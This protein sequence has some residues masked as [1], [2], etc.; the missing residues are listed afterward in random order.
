[1]N[2]VFSKSEEWQMRF[3]NRN[4]SLGVK[5]LSGSAGVR[6]DYDVL[7]FLVE[8]ALKRGIQFHAWMNPYRIYTTCK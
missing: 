7:G 1:M 5:I 3:M 2:A 4:M 8:E 6:P